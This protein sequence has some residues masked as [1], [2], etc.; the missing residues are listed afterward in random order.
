MGRFAGIDKAS[1]N[2][3]SAYEPAWTPDEGEIEI[4]FYFTW[5]FHTGAS[6]DFEHLVRL[7]EPRKL[8]GLGTQQID[9]SKPGYGTAGINRSV[10]VEEEDVHT[11][12]MEGA[13]QSLDTRY[14]PWGID[15]YLEIDDTVFGDGKKK[16]GRLKISCPV[17]RE[18]ITFFGC[19]NL[20]TRKFYWKKSE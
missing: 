8:R 18:R 11:L 4:P 10:E 15:P 9:C 3:K 2:D 13:I 1:L 6:G 16:G 7:L 19:L 5:E 14:T 17:K 12:D 20:P